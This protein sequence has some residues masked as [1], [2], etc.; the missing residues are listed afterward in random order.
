MET[1]TERL[2]GARAHIE[3]FGASE[4]VPPGPPSITLEVIEPSVLAGQYAHFHI[5]T[6]HIADG[7]RIKYEVKCM[8]EVISTGYVYIAYG[9]GVVNFSA[10]YRRV[11]AETPGYVLVEPSASTAAPTVQNYELSLIHGSAPEPVVFSVK[12]AHEIYPNSSDL[13][14]ALP[15]PSVFYLDALVVRESSGVTKRTSASESA[16]LIRQIW[17]SIKTKRVYVTFW[18]GKSCEVSNIL[19]KNPESGKYEFNPDWKEVPFGYPP[20]VDPF[21]IKGALE[22]YVYAYMDY[23]A[24]L[25]GE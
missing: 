9:V 10:P 20:A 13:P 23:E 4:R 15:L 16:D 3:V 8:G 17:Y 18:D 11:D 19:K 6:S 7:S 1:D 2:H 5:T 21:G 24:S 22:P 25:T 12:Y 14:K